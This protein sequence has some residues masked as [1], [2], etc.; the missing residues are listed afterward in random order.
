MLLAV[1]LT[2]SLPN[3]IMGNYDLDMTTA[4]SWTDSSYAK[5]ISNA[6]RI[7]KQNVYIHKLLDEDSIQANYG[8]A[9]YNTKYPFTRD[10]HQ[11][12]QGKE[13]DCTASPSGVAAAVPELVS[14]LNTFFARFMSDKLLEY[15]DVKTED[16]VNARVQHDIYHKIPA[17][18]LTDTQILRWMVNLVLDLHYPFS[19]GFRKAVGEGGPEEDI[20]ASYSLDQDSLARLFQKIQDAI[21]L[22]DV[23]VD[24]ELLDDSEDIHDRHPF[25]LFQKWADDTAKKSCEIYRDL[26]H[27][28]MQGGGADSGD[29]KKLPR[30]VTV[31]AIFQQK[32]SQL[33]QT[34][35][36]EAA[37][38]AVM[39]LKNIAVHKHHKKALEAGKGR[40][41]PRKYWKRD[42]LRNLGV[43]AIVVP[44]FFWLMRQFEQQKSPVRLFFN[45][46]YKEGW[47][48]E[49]RKL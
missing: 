42:L 11:Q 1:V 12:R 6:E 3:A 2:V 36:E 25:H 48:A 16:F 38:H 33:L 31:S 10:W 14:V 27:P 45:D 7:L 30:T 40:H 26:L 19:L 22:P 13:W 15:H 29:K 5:I 24:P 20:I 23:P 46:K 49:L 37:R 28:D 21:V 43:A 8:R 9:H 39:F 17:M 47:N 4:N 32:W 44:C 34:Q 35:M 41:H 18:D